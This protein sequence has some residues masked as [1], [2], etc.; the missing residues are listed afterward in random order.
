MDLLQEEVSDGTVTK[1]E[2]MVET[3]SY[4]KT[5]VERMK[6]KIRIVGATSD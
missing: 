4:V 3:G 2:D 1:V 5:K 6:S